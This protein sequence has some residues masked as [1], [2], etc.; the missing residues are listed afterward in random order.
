MADNTK[1]VTREDHDRAADLQ[2]GAAATPADEAAGRAVIAAAR[3]T[4]VLPQKPLI[5]AIEIENFKGIGAPV[6]I[7]L[8]PI[9]L[10]FG[11]NSAGKSTILQAL[12]Y[13]HEILTHRN[14]DAHKTELGGD[15]VDLG[16]FRQFVHGHDLNRV[17]RLRFE[18]N[19]HDWMV[20]EP[21]WNAMIEHE[22][23]LLAP[24]ESEGVGWI[25][26]NDPAPNVRS[27]SLVLIIGW[28]SLSDRPMLTGYEVAVEGTLFGRI[29]ASNTGTPKLELNWNHALLDRFHPAATD[30]SPATASRVAEKAEAQGDDYRLLAKAMGQGQETPLPDWDSVL[31]LSE[32]KWELPL[33]IRAEDIPDIYYLG[34]FA[35]GL[36]VGIGRTLR[37][38]L[39]SLRH[40]GPVR[41][42]RPHT[43]VEPDPHEQGSWSDGSAAWNLLVRQNSY[44]PTL[45]DS[46]LLKS[47]NDWLSHASRLDTGYKLR[48]KST[49]ELAGD[50]PWVGLIRL[51]ERCLAEF[52]LA[53]FRDE[54]GVVDVDRWVR[55]EAAKIATLYGRDRDE[56]AARIRTGHDHDG[57]STNQNDAAQDVPVNKNI[58][59]LHKFYRFLVEV[60]TKLSTSISKLEQ[61]DP[62]SDVKALVRA[63]AEARERPKVEIVTAESELPVRTSDIGVGVSQIL[64]VVTAALDPERP[65]IT[66]IEQPELHVHPKMQVELGDL[67]VAA[68]NPYPDAIGTLTSEPSAGIFLIETH[69]EHLILRLLRRIE[70]TH[71]GELPEGK[72]ALKPEQVSVVFLEQTGGEVRA[73][74]LRIDETGEFLDR[75]PQGFFE[76]RDDELF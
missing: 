12:C 66:A 72:P 38:E 36:L 8:R 50:A 49:I 52:Q 53:E 48:R 29:V 59:N 43:A 65:G 34:L 33:A 9:T 74:R 11:R 51:H 61:G 44:H 13:A 37:D 57:G 20:P 40:I 30:S 73:T 15:Q 63:I 76:E 14:A 28:S 31:K 25:L 45:P 58:E 41:E 26:D 70:E 32:E 47:V 39:A 21:V 71:D 1:P 55:K 24:F 2:N 23:D 42:L 54:N 17:V 56:L 16:G 62:P 10:L 68:L 46:N 27:G 69:S 67:F 64:P 6:R 5:T 22:H 3:R 75:W 18:L 4:S 35:S 7:D 60:V 19:L